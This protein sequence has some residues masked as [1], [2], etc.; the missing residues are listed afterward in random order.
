MRCTK[1]EDVFA[2][3]PEQ[4]GAVEPKED[5]YRNHDVVKHWPFFYVVIA[6]RRYTC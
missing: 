5:V 6:K 1:V 3:T 4:Q 2:D